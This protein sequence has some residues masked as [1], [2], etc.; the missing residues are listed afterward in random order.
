MKRIALL[1][2]SAMVY[3]IVLSQEPDTTSVN[4]GKKNIVTVAEDEEKTDVRVLD[5]NVVV[6]VNEDDTIKI[7]VGN[8]AIRITDTDQG[9]NIDIIKQ[10]DFDKHGWSKKE[11]KFKGH[12]AGFE[13]GLNDLLTPDFSFAGTV[14]ETNYLDLNTGRSW[15]A[16]I[17]FIQYSLPMS[18]GIGWVTGLGYERN[19]YSFD[20]NNSI[21]KDSM[22]NIGPI[23]P[24]NDIIYDKSKLNTNYL[25]LPLLL[26]FQFGPQKK[27]FVSFGVIGGLKLWSTAKTKYYDNG[28]KE[29]DKYRD[30][31][32]LSPFR[33]ALTVRAGYR[34]VNLYANYGMIP[35]F[36]RNTGPEVHPVNIG[37]I[38]IPFR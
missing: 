7:K 17:N 30:D 23:Y 31:F 14:P 1:L 10:E 16:N 21:G 38:L 12:W 33:Y 24:P 32:N 19:T 4:I 27:G 5:D 6:N 20:R 13:L 18:S 22:G 15:N 3:Q 36:T 35:L 26:E 25:T 37:L 8:K 28:N 2:L 29:K 11:K 9:T 34:F